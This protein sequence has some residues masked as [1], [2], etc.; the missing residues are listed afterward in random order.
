MANKKNHKAGSAI[1]TLA[2]GV[3]GAALGAT[4]VALSSKKNRAKLAQTL[5]NVKRQSKNVVDTLEGGIQK[6]GELGKRVRKLG[7]GARKIANKEK[8]KTKKQLS[9]GAK[10]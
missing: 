8:V 10:K 9:R 4:A 2:A 5:N 3:A 1:G 6:V 7:L